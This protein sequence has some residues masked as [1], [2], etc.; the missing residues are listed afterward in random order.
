M[1][2][3]TVTVEL[4]RPGPRNSHLLTRTTQYLGICGNAGAITV[5]LPFEHRKFELLLQDLNY[6]VSVQGDPTRALSIM[7]EA[8]GEIADMLA[9]IPGL[10]GALDPQT[11]QSQTLVQ[12]RI[13]LSAS[14]LAMLPFELAKVITGAPASGGWLALQGR[15]PLCITRHIRSVSSE[16]TQWPTV[17]RILF[18]SGP[19]TPYDDHRQALEQ[20]LAPWLGWNK[21]R[22]D[23]LVCLQEATLD[24][25]QRLVAEAADNGVPFSHVHILAHGAPFDETDKYS[26]VG[27]ALRGGTVAGEQIGNALN[28]KCNGKVSRPAVVTLASCDSARVSDVRTPS[29]SV[30]HE[31]HDAGICLVVASQFKLSIDGAKRFIEHFYGGQLWGDHPLESLYDA[32]S[33]LFDL[34]RDVHDWAAL[35]AYEAFPSDLPEQLDTFRYWQARRAQDHALNRLEE[36]VAP[37]EPD[38]GQPQRCSKDEFDA[39]VAK[40]DAASR[41]LPKR[42]A[43]ALEC[44]GLRAAAMKRIALAAFERAV[45][46]GTSPDEAGVLLEGCGQRLRDSRME[47]W[48]ATKLYL[49]P[50][51][52]TMRRKSNLHWLLGQVMSLDVVLGEPLKMTH[53]YAARLAAEIDSRAADDETRAW[54][55]V[56]LAELALLRL[57]DR[58]LAD[59][60]RERYANEAFDCAK[61]ILAAVGLRSEHAETTARQFDRYVKWWGNPKLGHACEALKFGDRTHWHARHG[62]V[63]TAAKIVELL[64]GTPKR[65][66]KA[67]V[68]DGGS[69][70]SA[71]PPLPAARAAGAAKPVASLARRHEDGS[72]FDVEMLPAENGD[73]LWIE[74]GD[75]RQP[76]RVL[77]DCGAE[78]TASAIAARIKGLSVRAGPAFDLFVLT[79]IDADHINGVLPLFGNGIARDCFADVWFNGYRQVSD[80][81]SVKQGEAFSALLADPARDL[82]W[83]RAT[84]CKGDRH[85]APIVLRADAALPS[86]V[87]PGGMRITI[88]SPGIP[89]L[90]RLGR[91]WGRALAEAEPER[92]MLGRRLP[93]EE[94]KD[95]DAFDL[96]AQAATAQGKD[97]SVP[98]GSSIAFLAEFGGRGVLFTGDAYAD[99][100]TRSIAALQKERGHAGEPLQLDALK[101]SHHGSRNA[102]TVELLQSIECPRYLVSTNGNIFYHPDREAIAR[103]ILRGGERPRLF[104]N[105]RSPYNALWDNARL[106][107]RYGYDC[108]YPEQ[109]GEG[110]R[111]S[112]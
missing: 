92:S 76:S 83:N 107:A 6:E 65:R 68:A 93:P 26:P 28:A 36:R 77:V 19:D 105:Y 57:S 67:P 102:T 15:V 75:A 14:E 73:C 12:L 108:A 23:P 39:L 56:S 104:F 45:D 54:A 53:W 90:K 33:R 85:P 95:F 34:G 112:L 44:A 17:P 69:S 27:I 86:Y 43:Y 37:C 31:L 55:Q 29:A 2:I 35:V 82:P 5:T 103:I 81:L 25:I 47:Y 100:L 8:G 50:A 13:V 88:L 110:L 18:A 62:L 96:E 109:G 46:R 101:L 9:R 99:V 20:V 4:L 60:E 84:T 40:A 64:G 21:W 87:L 94:V 24:D 1:D 22:A 11:E 70:G 10:A 48:Q 97:P 58:E 63:E 61:E 80:F 78:S 16:G 51:S 41:R 111:V 66:R 91:E 7:D 74:Y 79:H 42:G 98:N 3:R 59:A 30:A 106:R 71:S 89:Q 49:G 38:D 72:V 52:E 32:R